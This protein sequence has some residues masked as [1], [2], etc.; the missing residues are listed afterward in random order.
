MLIKLLV[1]FETITLEQLKEF[2]IPFTFDCL[3]TGII[4]GLATWFDIQLSGYILS[5]APQL[6]RTHWHQCRLLLKEPLAVNAGQR[7]NGR[8]TFK[9][10]SM[11]S[12]DLELHF[13]TEAN[14]LRKGHYCLHEQNYYFDQP[15]LPEG[16]KP[17]AFGLYSSEESKK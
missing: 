11:R 7:L 17:E 8:L 10:N 1:N 2:E 9:V 15:V 12:Y 6:E 14:I 3:Y 4:H 13:I 5:T 16:T